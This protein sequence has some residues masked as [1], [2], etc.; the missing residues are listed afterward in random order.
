MGGLGKGKSFAVDVDKA[1]ILLAQL[2][3]WPVS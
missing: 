2:G 1:F 3:L